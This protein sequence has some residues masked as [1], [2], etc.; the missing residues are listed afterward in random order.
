MSTPCINYVH[1]RWGYA[2]PVRM[3]IPSEAH[4]HSRWGTSPFSVRHI[5]IPGEAHLH[6]R[7]HSQWG[8][9]F[10]CDSLFHSDS[11][12]LGM[13]ILTGN[14]DVAHSE[15]RCASPGMDILT[16]NGDVPH[17]ECTG[18]GMWLIKNAHP[19]LEY[20]SSPGM[21][22]VYTGWSMWNKMNVL[23]WHNTLG[24]PLN[25]LYGKFVVSIQP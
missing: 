18:M 3:C 5:P 19:H 23:S 14:G 17:Q 6:S 4:P 22:I 12:P 8:C 24:S 1:S 9:L 16:G 25:H 11:S 13:H 15:W 7:S 20:I 2:F 10:H 21:H